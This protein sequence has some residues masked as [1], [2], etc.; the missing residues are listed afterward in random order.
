MQRD[1][2]RHPSFCRLQIRGQ[3]WHDLHTCGAILTRT[4]AR[5]SFCLQQGDPDVRADAFS[6]LSYNGPHATRCRY[7]AGPADPDAGAPAAAEPAAASPASSACN[8]SASSSESDGASEDSSGPR[9]PRQQ[10]LQAT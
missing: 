2:I 5:P 9:K 6:M 1:A 3:L 10:S 7:A 8:D 4:R